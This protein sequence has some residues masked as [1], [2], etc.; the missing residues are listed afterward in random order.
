MTHPR[1]L[2]LILISSLSLAGCGYQQSGSYSEASVKSGYRWA[3]LYRED[4][5]TVAV[6]IFTNRDFR[7]GV[8][9]RLT[10]ALI[11]Q[12]EAN[13]PYRVAPRERADTILE[14]EIVNIDIADLSRD[15]RANVPQEQLY[16]VTINFT[17]KDLR[18]GRIL[19]ER[20][21]FQQTAAFFATLG[22][23]ESVG[24]QDTVEKLALAI[25]QEM[26]ADW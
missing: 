2:I 23:P 13:T 16:F 26:Q 14:G 11:N 15:V 17:W 25:V 6:P 4:V 24:A 3:S 8:E 19:V 10:K 12:L 9:F 7:R 18:S 22:E 1:T 21:N 5:K 20:R